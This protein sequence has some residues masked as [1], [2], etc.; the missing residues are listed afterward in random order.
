MHILKI[1]PGFMMSYMIS[2]EIRLIKPDLINQL[3]NIHFKLEWDEDNTVKTEDWKL[4]LRF[5][6]AA[7]RKL[8]KCPQCGKRSWVKVLMKKD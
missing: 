3:T 2:Y 1:L 6:S 5:F 8:L 4:P 7:N